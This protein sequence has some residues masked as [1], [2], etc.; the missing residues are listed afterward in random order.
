[1]SLGQ[2]LKTMEQVTVTP[3]LCLAG[4]QG[5]PV[6]L[7]RGQRANLC[8]LEVRPGNLFHHFLAVWSWAAEELP[9]ITS[10]S[11]SAL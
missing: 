5:F 10:L 2:P 4:S 7:P 6:L 9:V 11:L 3:G 8:G 1:M